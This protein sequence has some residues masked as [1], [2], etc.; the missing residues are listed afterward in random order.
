MHLSPEA[1][2]TATTYRQAEYQDN[3]YSANSRQTADFGTVGSEGVTKR[4][5]DALPFRSIDERRA[6][7][8]KAYRRTFQWMYQDRISQKR[9]WDDLPNW[10]ATGRGYYWISGK[11][12]SGKSTLMKYI[13]G[14]TKTA[15][16]LQKWS[17]SS[18][19]LVASFFFWYAGTPLQKYQ[20]RATSLSAPE[21]TQ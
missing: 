12:G 19:F 18:E 2:Q 3:S 7:I 11:A 10:L 14:N 6:T 21:R 13:L 20:A 9:F 1:S 8:S 4:I 5:L 16:A 17:G 15:D